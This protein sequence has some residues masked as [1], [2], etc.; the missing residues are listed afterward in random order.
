MFGVSVFLT[1]CKASNMQLVVFLA[2]AKA[3]NNMNMK[4]II[5]SRPIVTLAK[6]SVCRH[7]VHSVERSTEALLLPEYSKPLRA[8]E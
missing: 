2:A 7:E 5:E 3:A 4:D 6:S 8:R 1:A